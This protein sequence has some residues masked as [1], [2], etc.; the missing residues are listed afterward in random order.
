[1]IIFHFYSITIV[2]PHV[3][4]KRLSAIAPIAPVF[5]INSDYEFLVVILLSLEIIKLPFH[6]C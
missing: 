1:M 6:Y 3:S 4:M 2:L 5:D